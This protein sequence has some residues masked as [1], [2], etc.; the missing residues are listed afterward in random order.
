MM[1]LIKKILKIMLI[2]FLALIVLGLGGYLFSA[3][4]ELAEIILTPPPATSFG[5]ARRYRSAL[6]ETVMTLE[7]N[8]G[9]IK[10]IGVTLELTL[11]GEA[12]AAHGLT[13]EAQSLTE[14]ASTP[15]VSPYQEIPPEFR[16]RFDV[17]DPKLL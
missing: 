2:V 15:S 13:G 1:D 4:P 7:A 10:L 9:Y 12:W 6:H 17:K 8:Y 5:A 3:F 11:T 14:E 16:R